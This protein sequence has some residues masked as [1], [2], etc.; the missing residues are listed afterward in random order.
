MDRSR[1]F[2]KRRLEALTALTLAVVVVEIVV[3]ITGKCVKMTDDETFVRMSETCLS[4]TV[5]M[6]TVGLV[7]GKLLLFKVSGSG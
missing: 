3:L 1:E 6:G 2:D 5:R 4:N 7:L